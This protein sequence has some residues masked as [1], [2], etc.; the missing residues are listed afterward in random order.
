MFTS[1]S[2]KIPEKTGVKLIMTKA[3]LPTPSQQG[4]CHV[5]PTGS[6]KA[7]HQIWGHKIPSTIP[8][9]AGSVTSGLQLLLL[10]S[11]SCED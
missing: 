11:S 10:V 5:F 1:N 9:L 4:P 3:G 6:D 7:Q 2:S 8:W